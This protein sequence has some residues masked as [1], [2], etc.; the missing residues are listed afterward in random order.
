MVYASLDDPK[1]LEHPVWI[2][3]NQQR[4]ACLNAKYY[5]HKLRNLE[6]EAF[7]TDI[8]IAIAAPTSGV[9][10]LAMWQS[11]WGKTIWAWL[12]TIATF[13]V[14]I[15]AAR[16]TTARI[17]ELEKRVTSYHALL[18]DMKD[19]AD[20]VRLERKFSPAAQKLY[21]TSQRRYGA[22]FRTP[23]P[24]ETD[25]KLLQKYQ[26]EVQKEMPATSFYIP[27]E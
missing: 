20:K 14:I 11:D 9:A 26:S 27:E 3:Y 12:P 17:K 7:W 5:G 4:T 15:K 21:E 23:P 8:V 10:A 1:R 22:L 13:L 18:F 19:I 2:V 16:K 25:E 6:R 24:S